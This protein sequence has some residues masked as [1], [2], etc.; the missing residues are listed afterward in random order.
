[1]LFFVRHYNVDQG[2]IY[3][4]IFVGWIFAFVFLLVHC[5]VLRG[6]GVRLIASGRRTRSTLLGGCGHLLKFIACADG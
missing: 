2:G 5:G 1:M 6:Q 3:D 4:E